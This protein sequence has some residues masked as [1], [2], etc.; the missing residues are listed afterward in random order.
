MGQGWGQR[1]KETQKRHFAAARPLRSRS[2][3]HINLPSPPLQL[4]SDMLATKGV[5]KAGAEKALEALAEKGKVVSA[6]YQ[7]AGQVPGDGRVCP[8]WQSIRGLP[9]RGMPAGP[10]HPRDQHP[11]CSADPPCSTHQGSSSPCAP[12]K[13]HAT[14]PLPARPM[15]AHGP[16]PHSLHAHTLLQV[17]KE[18]GKTKIFWPSQEGL[19]ALTPEE[20]AAKQGRL[21]EVQEDAKAAGD[22]VAALRRGACRDRRPE[23]WDRA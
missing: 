22:A 20:A 13:Q 12:V 10:M 23:V 21:K 6:R 16:D 1:C 9:L 15:R 5:K 14:L 4:V 3:S 7:A 17:R 11:P 18:F 19:A 2:I 8:W